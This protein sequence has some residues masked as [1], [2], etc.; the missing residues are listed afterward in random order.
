C[1]T[2]GASALNI[3]CSLLAPVVAL[4]TSP[5]SS[6]M[7][8]EWIPLAISSLKSLTF[9]Y[10]LTGWTSDLIVSLMTELSSSLILSL[11]LPL[12]DILTWGLVLPTKA[13]LGLASLITLT[14]VLAG[15]V[16]LP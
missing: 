15:L 1:P 6:M 9:S 14:L 12:L 16:I 7:A 11:I 13:T 5:D 10:R 2:S 3:A 8:E 4:A